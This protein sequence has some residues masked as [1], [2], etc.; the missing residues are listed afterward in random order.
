RKREELY[1]EWERKVFRP[2]Q[3]Q[4]EDKLAHTSTAEIEA[5]KAAVGGNPLV[6]GQ[7]VSADGRVAAF[8]LHYREDAAEHFANAD[9]VPTLKAAA[10]EWAPEATI[11]LTGAEA[12][13]AAITRAVASQLGTLLP[14]VLLLTGLITAIAFR[15]LRGAVLTLAVLGMGLSWTLAL[16]VLLE[17]PLTLVSAL[18]PPVVVTLGLAYAMHSQSDFLNR[19]RQRPDPAERSLVVAEV[20][21]H[22]RL[23][24]LLTGLTTVAGFLA[25][26]LNPLQAVR[27]FATFCALGVAINVFL[28]LCVLPILLNWVGCT[29]PSGD[30]QE[31][32]DRLATALADLALR[33]RRTILGG[34]A[35]V[36]L[37]GVIGLNTVEVGTN[38]VRGFAPDHP[39]RQDFEQINAQLSGVNSFSIVLE[40][41]VDDTF[42]EPEVLRA[43]QRL[44]GWLSEQPEVGATHSVVDHLQLIQRSFGE[45]AEGGQLV[46]DSPEQIKQLLLVGATP[47]LSGV[48]D[49]RFATAQ[50]IVRSYEENSAQIRALLQR[51]QPQLDRLPRRL[52]VTVTG[53]S[54]LLTATVEDIASGQWL[55]VGVAALVIYAV[56]AMLFT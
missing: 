36:L 15:S 7:L 41:F 56:L 37:A 30:G 31:R 26:L 9:Y 32:F 8:V 24:L 10:L 17:I 55:T 20:I 12:V 50:I 48:V 46:P 40:G 21:D 51:L 19:L 22:L 49:R 18:V 42:A 2:I 53:D 52:E 6:D 27:E 3:K 45:A 29:A 28:A 25:L 5:L 16:M 38:Y 33:R 14:L 4:I 44:Q 13:K 1:K 47:G 54:V 23:P 39:V 35:V 43:M 34:G 11:W